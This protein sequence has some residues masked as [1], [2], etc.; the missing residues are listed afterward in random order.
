MERDGIRRRIG[1]GKAPAAGRAAL[2]RRSVTAL[3]G[4]GGAIAAAAAPAAHAPRYSDE[5]FWTAEQR[6]GAFVKETWPERRLLVWGTPGK[7]IR[8]QDVLDP[9][10]VS[11]THLTLPTN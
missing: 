3:L 10:T 7:T 11:Y 1:S 9:A 6:K 5:R 2:L 4:M 8:G